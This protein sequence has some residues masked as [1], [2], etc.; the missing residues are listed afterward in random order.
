MFA[1]FW[2]WLKY[3]K[4]QFIEF[5]LEVAKRGG[6]PTVQVYD[7]IIKTFE[8]IQNYVAPDAGTT[9]SLKPGRF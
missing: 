7:T 3:L 4:Q 1:D 5:F 6:Q 9:I 2:L 8:G